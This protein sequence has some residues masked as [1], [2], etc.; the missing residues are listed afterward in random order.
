LPLLRFLIAWANAPYSVVLGTVLLFALLQATGVLGLLAGGD[1]DG[2][3]DV[4]GADADGHDVDGHEADH[5]GGDADGDDHDADHAHDAGR[6]AP[7][8]LLAPLGIGKLPLSLVWQ[9][10]GAIFGLAGL[11]LNARFLDAP[12]G[13]PLVSLAWTMPLALGAGYGVVAILARVLTPIFADEK[14]NATS[15]AELV[16]HTGIVISS[17]VDADF[18]EVR[19][20]D[21]TGHDLRI[22]CRIAPGHTPANEKD[23]VLVVDCDD[24][25]TLFVARMD[26]GLEEEEASESLSERKREERD[27]SG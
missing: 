10:Y 13:P 25:G 22:V 18:G 7:S 5:D 6:A 27:V 8:H 17:K 14:Q 3:D 1:H 2:G 15:R 20:H 11:S 23:E 4:D 21:K 26:E 24:A 12:H 19:I 9:V 16:G